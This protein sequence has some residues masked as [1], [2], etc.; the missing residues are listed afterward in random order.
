M[1]LVQRRDRYL[2]ETIRSATLPGGTRLLVL[3]TPGRT[4]SA[5]VAGIPFGSIDLGFTHPDTAEPV[6]VPAGVAHFLEHQLFKKESG[7]LSEE[8]ARHGAN[9][10]AVTDLSSTYYHFASTE[11]FDEC[12]DVLLQL[13]LEPHFTEENVERE[14]PIVESEIRMGEEMPD[15]RAMNALLEGLY[16]NHPVR[17]DVPGT[18]ESVRGITRETLALCHRVFYTPSE[19]VVVVAGDVDPERVARRARE[20]IARQK[21]T[22]VKVERK[23]PEEPRGV[24]RAATELSLCLP[25]P[26]LL[27]GWKDPVLGGTAEEVV[28][29][30]T[31][32]GVALDLLFGKGAALNARLYDRGLVDDSFSFAYFGHASY[33][34]T[35]VGGDT[36]DPERLREEL[37]AGVRRARREGVRKRDIERMRRKYLGRYVRSFDDPESAAFSMFGYAVRGVD[38]LDFPKWLTRLMPRDVE[39]RLAAHLSDDLAAWCIA[40]PKG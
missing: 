2:R 5:A 13:V 1:T 31:A 38:P 10:N 28:R 27:L 39:E 9:D 11:G 36:D 22:P 20:A 30:E 4:K 37:L 33:G 25:R 23:L 24:H 17:I 26:K 3:A 16:A 19:L 32:T 18:V 14:R 35:V 15:T 7:D 40:R 8:F 12:L 29:R 6:S 21:R 34:F